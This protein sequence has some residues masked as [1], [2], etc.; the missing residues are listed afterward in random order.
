MRS[1][2]SERL[3]KAAVQGLEVLMAEASLIGSDVMAEELRWRGQG[4]GARRLFEELVIRDGGSNPD[5][6]IS[7]V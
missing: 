3:A 7:L 1:E 5:G 4:A 6:I 2:Q